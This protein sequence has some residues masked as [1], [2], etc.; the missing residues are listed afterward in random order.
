MSKSFIIRIIPVVAA[1]VLLA[2]CAS[3]KH[4]VPDTTQP[5]V[6]PTSG[7]N[8]SKAAEERRVQE[9]NAALLKKVHANATT[10]QNITSKID[11]NLQTG[12]KNITVSGKLMMRRDDVIRIQLSVPILGVEAGRLEFTKDYVMIVDRIHNEYIKGDYNQ[13]DFLRN[14]GINF[15]SLQ[16]L[17]WNTLFV[18]G[19]QEVSEP[20]LK[21]F[22]VNRDLGKPESAISLSRSNMQYEWQAENAT[23]LIRKTDVT[24]GKNTSSPS[25]LTCDYDDFKAFAGKK[26]PAKIVLDMQTG[27]TKKAK[28][29]KLGITLKTM[30]QDNDWETR[31]SLSKKY[32]AVS[33][34][35]V[36]N[37]I[38]A[39]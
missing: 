25:K 4:V 13:V 23:G 17:F 8:D 20:K 33:V 21:A 31:T 36:M 10:A 1:A 34:E 37:K 14:N 38:M 18:P 6:N 5:T 39:L 7:N 16:A 32:K 11:F 2:S 24:Y 3:K 22:S 12:S 29:I 9:A 19:E 26:F 30:G 15:Y 27:S 28:N 35:E